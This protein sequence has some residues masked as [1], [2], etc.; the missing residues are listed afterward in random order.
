MWKK[1]IKNIETLFAPSVEYG[2]YEF[3]D[4][5]FTYIFK[6]SQWYE[7]NSE[8]SSGYSLPSCLNASA[9]VQY[10][11]LEND[12]MILR[13]AVAV[14]EKIVEEREYPVILKLQTVT[15]AK[16]SEVVMGSVSIEIPKDLE[17]QKYD[18]AVT[19]LEDQKYPEA[20]DLFETLEDYE[21]SCDKALFCWAEQYI[22]DAD[23]S[24]AV[25]ALEG[26]SPQNQ[27]HYAPLLAETRIRA[28]SQSAAALYAKKDYKAALETLSEVDDCLSLVEDMDLL[29]SLEEQKK[30]VRYDYAKERRE[31]GDHR[32]VIELLEGIDEYLDS[33][34]I[35]T[36]SRYTYGVQLM[37]EG[38][39]QWDPETF[40]EGESLLNKTKG[41]QDSD[42]ILGDVPLWKDYINAMLGFRESYQEG[43]ARLEKLPPDFNNAGIALKNAREAKTYEGKYIAKSFSIG[44]DVNPWVVHIY[45]LPFKGK[46]QNFNDWVNNAD[47]ELLTDDSGALCFRARM[48]LIDYKWTM[49]DGK[50]I[51]S[52]LTDTVKDNIFCEFNKIP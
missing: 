18:R 7:L 45:T 3:S 31:A 42:R 14:P 50:I 48:G 16:E 13:G 33:S 41:Y 38:I 37:D 4:V 17:E 44:F 23:Y 27:A 19:L 34:E 29:S 51:V 5:W 40:A 24:R 49:K 15:K 6:E 25:A 47:H 35:L 1:R 39:G 2:E 36:E 9:A 10:M 30:E 8:G 20:A 43:I 26:I 11:P 32:T 22:Q 21:D 28:A 12:S 52:G 46:E